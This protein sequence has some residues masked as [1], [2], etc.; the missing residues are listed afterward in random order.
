MDRGYN[1]GVFVCLGKATHEVDVAHAI[2]FGKF[3]SFDKIHEYYS[4]HG[5]CFVFLS[6]SL[7]K[8]KKKAEQHACEKFIALLERNNLT[9]K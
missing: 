9:N 6:S 4:Q 7:H 3:K 1:M 8:I 2:P 5:E